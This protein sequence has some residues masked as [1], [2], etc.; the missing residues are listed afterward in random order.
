MTSPLVLQ[1]VTTTNSHE[2]AMRIARALVE[3]RLVACAQVSGPVNSIY[4]WQGKVQTDE[5][6]RCSVKTLKSKYE[7][8][9]SA[10]RKLH[11]YDE[12]EIVATE[13]VAGSKSYLE[14]VQV[15]CEAQG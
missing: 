8:V 14:W 9:E 1:I 3:D 11:T 10:M 15:Q 5:E 6:W 13:I 4:R 2:E 7:E 12:P